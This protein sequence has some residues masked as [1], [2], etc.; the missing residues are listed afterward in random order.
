MFSRFKKKVGNSFYKILDKKYYR[1]RWLYVVLSYFY[2][3]IRIR[4]LSDLLTLS[5]FKLSG[6]QKI[7][8]LSGELKIVGDLYS[9][10]I[11]NKNAAILI[12]HGTSV[13]GRKSPLVLA[14]ACEFQSLGYLVLTIDLRGYGESDDPE[15]YN[16]PESFDFAQD[17]ISAID[18]L[19][20]NLKLHEDQILVIGHS[21]GCGAALSAQTREQIIRKLVLFG[22]SRRMSERFFGA[23]PQEVERFLVRARADMN[24]SQPLPLPLWLEVNRSLLIENYVAKL[25]RI[26]SKQ[27]SI[28]LVDAEF[29]EEADLRFL[30]EIGNSI[31]EYSNL[32]YWTVPSTDHYLGTGFILTFPCYSRK[33]VRHFVTRLNNWYNLLNHE[34][35]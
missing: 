24:L 6:K 31:R 22:P 28:F 16:S 25:D 10:A 17:V 30:E 33:V 19:V 29:E 8:F 3:Q 1:L 26:A 23:A 18:Y 7:S 34:E 12:L 4:S 27:N 5:F 11:S 20:K 9:P 2:L 35:S 13:F 32:T 14:L 21:F 15:N